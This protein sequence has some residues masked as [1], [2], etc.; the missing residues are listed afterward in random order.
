MFEKENINTLAM[1]SEFMIALYGSFAQAE[2]ESISKNVSWGVEKS[3]QNAMCA[4]SIN[5]GLAIGEVWTAN[6]KSSRTRRKP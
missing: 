4:T 2:S 5:I 1:T 3:F 6:P